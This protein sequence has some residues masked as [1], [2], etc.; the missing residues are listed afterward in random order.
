M[1]VKFW[2]V[3]SAVHTFHY[4]LQQ[5]KESY[6]HCQSKLICSLKINLPFLGVYCISSHFFFLPVMVWHVFIS[7][8]NKAMYNSRQL[9]FKIWRGG[10][11]HNLQHKYIRFLY[12]KHHMYWSKWLSLQYLMLKR[13]LIVLH[14]ISAYY[15]IQAVPN[16][17]IDKKASALE[18]HTS[19]L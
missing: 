1:L 8:N 15:R 10:K 7:M 18:S 2:G 14:V 13:E 17:K 12:K 19:K 6:H 5:F 3:F 9:S 16:R 11:K 4:S